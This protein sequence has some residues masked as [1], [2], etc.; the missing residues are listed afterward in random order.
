MWPWPLTL[1]PWLLT[2]DLEN[3]QRISCDVMK[4]CIKFERN[5]TINGG[6]IAITMFDLW[7]WTC[8][9]CCAW[10]CDNFNRVWPS[11]TYPCL[12]YSVFDANT[13]CHAVTLTF[14]LFILNF[15]ITSGVM[16][17]N[18]VQNFWAKSNNPRLS[19][20]RFSA[21]SRAILRGGSELTE[22]SQ[23]AWTQLHQILP[24]HR[25][26]IAALY[27]VSEF[28]YLA[29]FSNAGGSKLR[30]VLNDGKFRTF[31]PL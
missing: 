17:S 20:R 13:L 15:Y 10:L 14:D 31:W 2:F 16:R 30:D 5:Q 6:V 25:A 4:L 3:L 8:F 7:P 19:Y 27:F 23:G 28:G 29:A 1:W 22:L 24:E 11:T 21:F 12:N 9:K 18:S 26:I